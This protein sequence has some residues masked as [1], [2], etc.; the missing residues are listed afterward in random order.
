MWVHR[1][2]NQSFSSGRLKGCASQ[3]GSQEYRTGGQVVRLKSENR[4]PS[5]R[6]FSTLALSSETSSHRA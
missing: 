4:E 3:A 1:P 6:V 2:M 5:G